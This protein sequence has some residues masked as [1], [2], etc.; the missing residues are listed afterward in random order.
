MWIMEFPAIPCHVY[1]GTLDLSFG[2]SCIH[3]DFSVDSSRWQQQPLTITLVLQLCIQDTP[4][5]DECGDSISSVNLGGPANSEAQHSK[6][7]ALFFF[8]V[9]IFFYVLK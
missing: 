1:P 7:S 2:D 8:Q 3:H 4:K 5:E 6:A 9:F